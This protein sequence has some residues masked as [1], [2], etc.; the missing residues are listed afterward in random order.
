M[1]VRVGLWRKLSTKNWCYWTVVLE[2]TL[3]SPVDCKEIQP[4]HPE[5][6]QSWVFIGKTDAE[7]ET[8]LLWPPHV[9]SW[10]T[11]KTLMLGGIGGRRRRGRQRMRWL[12]GITD[13]MGMSLSRLWGLVM[14]REAWRAVIHGVAECRTW[15]SAWTELSW[16]LCMCSSALSCSVCPPLVTPRTVANQASL[17]G[18]SPA[19]NT[20]MGSRALRQ[21]IFPTQGPN[22]SLPHY[23][24]I[25]C[26]LSQQGS[27]GI[28]EWVAYPFSRG[29]SQPG[30]EWGSPALRV[31]SLPAELPGKPK[32]PFIMVPRTS[33]WEMKS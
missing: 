13:S 10:L 21:G 9:K 27:P 31:D 4:V 5:G 12:D 3:E 24:Q 20:R 32:L 2:K 8:P 30:I 19:K 28:V 17:H 25:V 33:W 15:P 11:G 6:D 26:H 7:A 1:D 16:D 14:D 29:S 22:P 18:D 23:R